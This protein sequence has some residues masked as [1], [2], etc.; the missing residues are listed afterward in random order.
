MTRSDREAYE[1]LLVRLGGGLDAEVRGL[2]L[3]R[4]AGAAGK[5]EGEVSAKRNKSDGQTRKP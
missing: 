4:G 3:V 2:V 5:R 1:N